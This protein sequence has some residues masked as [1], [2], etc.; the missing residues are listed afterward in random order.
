M[1]KVFVVQQPARYDRVAGGFV[2]K[3]DLTPATK[4][5]ELVYLLEPGN[6]RADRVTQAMVSIRRGLLAMTADDYILPAGDPV[7]IMMVAAAVA[8]LGS[9]VRLLKWDGRTKEYEPY[10][11]PAE[12]RDA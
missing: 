1:S 6:V 10:T 7:A 11:I 8:S 4:F 9:D 12:R 5:G 3:Y 2:P